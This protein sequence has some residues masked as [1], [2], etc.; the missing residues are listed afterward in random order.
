LKTAKALGVLAIAVLAVALA[1]LYLEGRTYTP[2]ARLSLPDGLTLAAVLPDAKDR[3][4]CELAN[5]RFLAPFRSGCK[6]CKV[7]AAR[8]ER[9]LEGLEFAMRAGGAVP[10]PVVVADALRIAVLGPAQAASAG[11]QVIA[12]NMVARGAKSATCVQPQAG[13]AKP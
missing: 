5:Q 3:E 6:E 8:C 2:V 11:C 4:K 7:S 10:H 12:A 9:R 1:Y 13:A